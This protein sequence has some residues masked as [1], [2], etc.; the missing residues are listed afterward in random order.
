MKQRWES[1][2][3][4]ASDMCIHMRIYFCVCVYMSVYVC[5]CVCVVGYFKQGL[6][7]KTLAALRSSQALML[8]VCGVLPYPQKC[9]CV[10]DMLQRETR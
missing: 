2:S 7:V 9:V 5:P 10:S 8:K 6:P 3:A 4:C 1:L